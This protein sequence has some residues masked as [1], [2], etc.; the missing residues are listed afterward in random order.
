MLVAGSTAVTAAGLHDRRRRVL[1]DAART[2]HCASA[3][4][5]EDLAVPTRHRDGCLARVTGRDPD[6]AGA[7]QHRVG[8]CR[9]P[10][11]SRR[12]RSGS[13]QP[14]RPRRSPR[15]PRTTSSLP[16]SDGADDRRDA[17]ARG[18]RCSATRS[19][20]A[21]NAAVAQINAAGGVL[22]RRVELDRASTRATRRQPEPTRADCSSTSDVDAIVGPA[23]STIALSALDEHR[24]Q[25][26]SWPARRPRSALALDDFP[27]DNLFFRTVPS[28]SMQAQAIAQVAEGPASTSVAIAYVDDAYGRPLAD[29]P[30]P[31]TSPTCRSTWPT[32]SRSPAARR[33]DRRRPDDSVQRIRERSGARSCSAAATTGRGSSRRSA[34]TADAEPHVDHRERRAPR[35]PSRSSALAALPEATAAR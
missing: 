32:R 1:A 5:D 29:V 26:A 2:V 30:S 15:P 27:D 18:R 17:P 11:R 12:V 25:T 28:D 33:P 23:S 14:T 20:T 3:S 19:S 34:T 24:L 35:R 21:S 31:R 22:G 10:S 16:T 4:V 7:T 9:S 6:T 13:R 8:R